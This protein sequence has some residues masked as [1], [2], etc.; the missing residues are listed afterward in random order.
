MEN[1]YHRIMQLL[2]ILPVMVEGRLLSTLG[3]TRQAMRLM[4]RHINSH[5]W[6]TRSFA[7]YEPT[8]QDVF[9]ATFAK[10]G[11]NWMMQI[12]QQIAYYGAVEFEHIHDL[13]PWPDAP[14]P[15]IRARLNDP[16]IVQR[17][18]SSLRII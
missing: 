9:I 6:K 2:S 16:T 1:N 12:A 5:K 11:T 8:A 3:K 14:F 18:P 10:S 15:K 17:S 13:V 7:G 4:S